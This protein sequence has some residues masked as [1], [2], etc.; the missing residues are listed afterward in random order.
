MADVFYVYRHVGKR[1]GQTFYVGKGHGN[2]AHA[3]GG[4]SHAWGEAVDDEGGFGVVFEATDL[5][6]ADAKNLEARLIEKY[7]RRADGGA[8]VNVR[9]SDNA[10]PSSGKVPRAFGMEPALLERL[11]RWIA[12]QPVAPSKTAVLETALNEWLDRQEGAA[13]HDGKNVR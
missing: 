7:G 3:I 10:P 5:P 4:R 1:T 12:T 13:P 8:L 6:E 2:R 9:T 11:E